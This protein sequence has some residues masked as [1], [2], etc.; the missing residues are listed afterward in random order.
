MPGLAA[1]AALVAAGCGSDGRKPTGSEP[2]AGPPPGE[3]ADPSRDVPGGPAARGEVAF[4]DGLIADLVVGDVDGAR[5]GY[6]AALAEG[7]LASPVATRAALRWATVEAASGRNLRAIELVARASALAEGDPVLVEAADRLRV[8][9]SQDTDSDVRGPPLGTALAGVDAVTA[10]RFATAD[11]LH[12]RARRVRVRPVM[13]KLSSSIRAREIATEAAVRAYREVAT[14]GGVAAIA[15][16]YRIGSIYHDLAI[17]L[18]FEPPA[19]LDP[20]VASR[21]RR[22]LRGSALGYLRRAVV[23][24]R[25]AIASVPAAGGADIWHSA[26][27]SEL[28]A[29]TELLGDR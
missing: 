23:A 19:E 29:A 20:S 15:A 11:R 7:A 3:R 6:Q 22:T 18:V 17:A 16:D 13:H 10:A 26:A 24:Y 28:R 25:R 9:V 5:A 27:Q 8:A 12:D 14:A 2:T 4:Y 1:L 21:F